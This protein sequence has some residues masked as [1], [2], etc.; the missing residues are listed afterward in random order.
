MIDGP[1]CFTSARPRARKRHRCCECC[2]VIEPGEVYEQ[3]SGIWDGEPERFRTCLPCAELRRRYSDSL[4]ADGD[5]DGVAY[6]YLFWALGQ[7]EWHDELR[8][9]LPRLDKTGSWWVAAT[10]RAA[11]RNSEK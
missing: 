10:L 8:A 5:H 7:A 11:L 6:T 2:G 4:K 9:A 3:D 1:T